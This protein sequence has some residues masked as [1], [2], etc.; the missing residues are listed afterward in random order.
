P[1]ITLVAAKSP[2]VAVLL[3]LLWLG[4]GHL[5]A[6][7]VGVGV[8]WIIVDGVLFLLSCTGIGLIV[9]VPVW[10]VAAIITTITAAGAANA[11]NRRNGIIV[12]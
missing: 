2:G 8:A 6:G 1:P 3:S 11:F 7:S 4:A 9:S 12:R 5:Y 10:I